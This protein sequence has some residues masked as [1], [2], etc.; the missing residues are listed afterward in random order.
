MKTQLILLIVVG[1]SNSFKISS[2]EILSKTIQTNYCLDTNAKKN[3]AGKW[4]YEFTSETDELLNRTF[5]LTITDNK[6][7]IKGNYCAVARN[8]NKIDCS[9][10]NNISGMILNDTLN[11]SFSGIFDKKAK[12]RAEIYFLNDSLVWSI[13]QSE[14]EIY[15]P[16]KCT[17]TKSEIEPAAISKITFP[18]T[19]E[20]ILQLNPSTSIKTESFKINGSSPTSI[21]KIKEDIFVLYFDGDT[22]RYYLA[23]I[24][25]GRVKDYLLVG[26]NETIETVNGGTYDSYIG[27][28]IDSSLNIHL[29]YS[30]GKNYQTRKKEKEESFLITKDNKFKKLK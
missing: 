7:K 21:I 15:A 26:K 27:F 11:V 16:K 17:L 14:G 12:G 25:N 19:S 1:L 8:G 2:E 23:T 5:D 22:E 4:H 13:I 20:N 29:E 18:V 24:S 6:G 9:N 10:V 30:K 3:F 28:I